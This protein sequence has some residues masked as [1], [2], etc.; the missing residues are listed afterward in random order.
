MPR[1]N[2]VIFETIELKTN[3]VKVDAKDCVLC[4]DGMS[5]KTHLFYNFSHDYI[6]GF[7]NSYDRKTHGQQSM[8]SALC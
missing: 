1:L 2:D 8:Y 4:I 7:N 3:N 6:L 5:I